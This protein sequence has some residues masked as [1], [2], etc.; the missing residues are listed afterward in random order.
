VTGWVVS[1]CN[2][3]GGSIAVTGWVV[4]RTDGRGHQD[5][6]HALFEEQALDRLGV[7]HQGATG[8][9][10]EIHG[11]T[12]LSRAVGEAPAQDADKGTMHGQGGLRPNAHTHTLTH[13]TTRKGYR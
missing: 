6:A 10:R 5:V 7:G 11:H 3:C 2:K 8:K 4:A 13:P 1:L 9:P 12:V